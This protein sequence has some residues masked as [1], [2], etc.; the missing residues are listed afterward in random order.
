MIALF[1]RVLRSWLIVHISQT[2]S[3]Y[4]KKWTECHVC[5]HS[6]EAESKWTPITDPTWTTDSRNLL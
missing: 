2:G 3:H 1:I 6:T 4:Q 5:N